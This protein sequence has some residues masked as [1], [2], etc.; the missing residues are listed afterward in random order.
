M[1]SENTYNDLSFAEMQE[2]VRKNEASHE[3]M[4][5][6][7]AHPEFTQL[8]KE[9][10]NKEKQY[11]DK[12]P[13]QI[14]TVT[15]L[16]AYSRCMDV[17]HT[18]NPVIPV[19]CEDGTYEWQYQTTLRPAPRSIK[20]VEFGSIVQYE[21]DG[22]W[23]P[24]DR[25][26]TNAEFA[27]LFSC[28][29]GVIKAYTTVTRPLYV[30]NSDNLRRAHILWYFIGINDL[31]HHVGDGGIIRE[32]DLIPSALYPYDLISSR[33]NDSFPF[34][35]I[36][37][38][39]HTLQVSWRAGE[40]SIVDD[41]FRATGLSSEGISLKWDE[42]AK[43]MRFYYPGGSIDIKRGNGTSS[44]HSMLMAL[45]TVFGTTHSIRYVN[46]G[47][48]AST[49]LFVVEKHSRWNEL[50]NNNQFVRWFFTPITLLAD[51]F[52]SDVKVLQAAGR[53]YAG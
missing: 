37:S 46:L 2:K 6:F 35:E 51:T 15:D 25:P 42:H 31:G 30:N 48:A 19:A 41:F 12:L 22:P 40:D 29:G 7:F 5:Q 11:N 43:I 50:E 38:Y 27:E 3:L 4:R 45:Q 23:Y 49:A 32:R 26:G 39:P 24:C 28:P 53:R 10:E 20:I 9:H 16:M 21:E 13:K 52:E 18:P 17:S 36:T 34:D 47:D 14:H 1:Q 33:D 8:I 44:Q